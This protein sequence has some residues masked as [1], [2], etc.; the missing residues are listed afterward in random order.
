MTHK[1][2]LGHF[3]E[4]EGQILKAVLCKGCDGDGAIYQEDGQLHGTC[5]VCDGS[6]YFW[7]CTRCGEMFRSDEATLDG[8]LLPWTDRHLR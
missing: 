1:D 7:E 8:T 3:C 6:G 5:F 2:P 4:H